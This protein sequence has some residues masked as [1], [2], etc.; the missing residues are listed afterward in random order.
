VP[1]QRLELNT[2]IKAPIER[3][4]DLSRSIELHLQSSDE[5]AIAG[6][7]TGL[8]GNGELVTWQGRH[9][10]FLITHTTR[11]SAFSFPRYFQD[12]MVRGAFRSYCH[13]HYFKKLDHGT[14]MIDLVEFSAP[15]K[16]VGRAVER[17]FL[18]KHMR[19]L[20]LRRN[21]AIKQV[22]ESNEWTKY[23]SG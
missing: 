1:L 8:I 18:E 9:F 22:A 16:I 7:T 21:Q 23:L 6:V 3:C 13:D 17:L 5:R 19:L 14:M 4:F 11:I 20:L 15:Y 12:S 10:G 2:E